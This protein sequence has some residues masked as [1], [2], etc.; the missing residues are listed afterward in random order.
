[1]APDWNCVPVMVPHA[2]PRVE[3]VF[4]VI[5]VTVGCPVGCGLGRELDVGADGTER[6]SPSW[7]PAS[8]TESNGRTIPM[9]AVFF[10]KVL[11]PMYN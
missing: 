8:P 11:P 10:M 2:S 7:Q 6:E 9:R 5:A 3:P 4:G 1:M